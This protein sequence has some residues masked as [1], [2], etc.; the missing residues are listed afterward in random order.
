MVNL[1]EESNETLKLHCVAA[2]KISFACHQNAYPVIRELRIENLSETQIDDL[3]L[4]IES[5]PAF[6]KPKTW[7]IDRIE[8]G[9]NLPL[10]FKD[11][12]LKG[13]F[14][15]DLM[16]SVRGALHLRIRRKGVL[17]AEH[18]QPIELLTANEWGGAGYMPELLAAFCTPND[19]VV[20]Q[21]LRDAGNVLRR[22]GKSDVIDGYQSG[23]RQRVWEVA[24]A[25][26]A[27]ISN[28]GVS[29]AVPPSSF[30][31]DGQK[32][33][34]PSQIVKGG[35]A[36]CLDI[37]LLMAAV[38][39]Q[40]GLNSV[41]AL[42]KGH[43]LVGVWLQPEK[44][45][46]VLN[47]E[48]EV[49]RK[50]CQLNEL[51]ILEPTF[52]TSQP[53][54]A[55]SRAI[56]AAVARLVAERDG[57][58]IT[59]VDIG[60]AR[61]HRISPIGLRTAS[62]SIQSDLE[63]PTQVDLTLEAAPELPDF[64]QEVKDETPETAAGRLERWQR[65]LLDLSARN[66]LLNHRTTKSS[67]RFLCPDPEQLEDKLASGAKISI[68]ALPVAT[69][70]VQD[71][72]LHRQRSGEH[73]DEA[74]AAAALSENQ[75]LAELP[76]PELGK[77]VTEIYRKAKSS[78]QEGGANTL[79]LALGFLLWKRDSKD[80]RRFRAPLILLPVSLERQSIRSGVKMLA[81][82][83]E[84]RFN[85]TLLEMLQKDFGIAIKGYE[86]ALPSDGSGVDVAA[87]WTSVRRAVRDS[88][89]F[90]VVEDVV[91]GHFSFAKYLM[92][93]D[94]VD[95][96]DDL[97]KSPVV[98]HLIDS[99][100]DQY[101]SSIEFVGRDEIDRKYKPNDFLTPLP[102]DA[103][104]M[105][106]VATADRGKDFV[107]IGPPGTGKSQTISNLIAHMLGSGRTVLFVSEKT[108]ALEVVYRRL[109]QVG[110][111]RFCLQLHSNKA[112]K[113]DVLAQLQEAWSSGAERTE[114]EWETEAKQLE[115]LRDRLNQLVQ[116][117]H[118]QAR[119]GLTAHFAMGIK[120][121]DEKFAKRI[122]L[123]W[124]T[125]DQHTAEDL[126]QMREAVRSL[127]IQARAVGDISNSPFQAIARGDWSPS[128]EGEMHRLSL[129]LVEAAQGI[130]QE[131]SRLCSTLG[132]ELPDT[133]LARLEGLG[134]LA[135][136]LQQSYRKQAAGALGADG[137]ILIEALESA[138]SHL[139]AYAEAQTRLSCIY[140]PFAWRKLD[141]ADLESR[142]RTAQQHWFLK[143]FFAQRRITKEMKAG[144]AKDTPAPVLDAPV[145]AELRK[146]GEAIDNLDSQLGSLRDWAKHD[147]DPE[148]VDQ[149]RTLATRLRSAVAKL[150]DTPQALINARVK[151][152]ALL[153]EGNDLLAPDAPVGRA[154]ESY[155]G[156][157]TA[158]GGAI[159][160][161]DASAGK[162][163]REQFANEGHALELI[164]ESAEKIAENC[165]Q[166]NH[167]CSW[168]RE[169]NKA[170]ELG[171]G[172]LV[173][174]IESGVVPLEE[175]P[176]TFTAA[177]CNWWSTQLLNEDE[178]LRTF[179]SAAH[180]D[181][182]NRFR[183]LDET[184][185][186]VT[187][188]YVAARM[189]AG[190]PG[191]DEGPRSSQWGILKHQM[192]LRTRHKPV[193]QL[194]L[195]A[196]EAIARLAP[197]LM[198]SPLSVAQYL[199]ADKSLFDLVIFDE[200]SQ[201]S[202][203]D[204]VGSLARGKQII[205]AGD[206][207][208]MPPTNFFAR[209]DD[210]ADGDIDF[211]GDLESIL[212]ELRSSNV[213]ELV[214]N[215]HYRSRRES[216][217]AFSNS[218]YYDN[219]LVTFPAPEQPDNGLRLVAPEGFYDRGKS[220]CN[221]GEA[222]AIVE[223]IV[224]RLTSDDASVRQRSIG[225]VTFNT[226]QQSLIEDLLDRAR[227]DNPSLEAAFS[228]SLAEPVFVKNLETVQGDER[229]VILF[230]IT[231]GPDRA[232]H[233]TMNFG[234]LNRDGGERRLNVALTRARS[235]M[236]VF[237]TLKPE[238]IDL[239]RTSAR[240][241]ADLKHFLEYAKQGPAA[242]GSAVHGSIGDF[243]SP[244]ESAVARGLRKRGW[245]IHPQIGVSA[246]RIDLGVVHP[247]LPGVYLAGVECDG[248][249]YHSSAYARERDK[250]RQSV[251]ENL[252]WT[253]FRVWST[254]WWV[255]QSSA[256]NALDLQ[257]R[258]HLQGDRTERS[259]IKEAGV[260]ESESNT[261]SDNHILTASEPPLTQP[262]D[263]STG[264]L[265][266]KSPGSNAR[267][268]R[269]D[270]ES[271]TDEVGVA[272][273]Q[274]STSDA[275][276]N[277]SDRPKS[278]GTPYVQA[279]LKVDTGTEQLGELSVDVLIEPITKIVEIESPIHTDDVIRRIT[280]AAGL[281]RAGSRIQ[282]N[283]GKAI[284]AAERLKKIR[285]KGEFLWTS[286]RRA[287]SARDRTSLP[288]QDKKLERV[289]PEEIAIALINVVRRH[290]T[291]SQEDAIQESARAL[292][293]QRVT[294]PM[295]ERILTVMNRLKSQERIVEK[296]GLLS[297]NRQT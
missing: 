118:R 151:I 268:A 86:S 102:A 20:D 286:E 143:R 187:A 9:A 163:I 263:V 21:I 104:Q 148:K 149:L 293:F 193:R 264:K 70:Q 258:D 101:P 33:R 27:A 251:L 69:S 196:P 222:R 248:A 260:G 226:Q 45:A 219:G 190:L 197:C 211:E 42:V 82:D 139:K 4:T 224:S 16:E 220:R 77:R 206:P 203:W 109:E 30:E 56:E 131:Q 175:I 116:H 134:E 282:D 47:D 276:T 12:E 52:V 87:I 160:A 294:A 141:G 25:A 186:K 270:S 98:K 121:R 265:S 261:P 194:M 146:H 192:A 277:P 184:F 125:A 15:I 246:F 36:T 159:S 53:S 280:H 68:R 100:R 237:S 205:V 65:K 191:Q 136:A 239:K 183:A 162:S 59:A 107:L 145:L 40:A 212:D 269:E 64:D 2:A 99:P 43:A 200:A 297:E 231:F 177:Y 1:A 240:A 91:L 22:A 267:S 279:V 124:A 256:L 123:E 137:Q 81:H 288:P 54:P 117:L 243:E 119:N 44:L 88:S 198:M 208:Q 78:L 178:V 221:E 140:D 180:V 71:R 80:E 95:R 67:I 174:G 14:L 249:M 106:A 209:A 90:E 218:H 173:A 215:L 93:K 35:V 29:Y 225:V 79:Y 272:G 147:S 155:L 41:I 278:L 89:G 48:A 156:A 49:L 46:S 113:A 66:P 73:I 223:E 17:V 234:P 204:A 150:V 92:W 55:F 142:W 216:L 253:L 157:L 51:V 18:S 213:S 108:A 37:A 60:R 62:A 61:A 3:T 63:K 161:F 120:I 250:I 241:V 179:S 188:R 111:G 127:Q 97:R 28:L 283:L 50:R 103:S 85:T 289:A 166:L 296:S 13:Q 266:S 273:N 96:T 168:Q 259:K 105:A 130:E 254:D 210:D 32:I 144:G 133:A 39:E 169:R 291:L 230:S 295:N 58:F 229:D 274:Q 34:F 170:I 154:T 26:Y 214:L 5:D 19:P 38:F 292:G 245:T 235:E 171:L 7:Q 152:R 6:L 153:G 74:Y 24:G 255:D 172:N 126:E 189:S 257:I 236:V 227:S 238:M 165:K 228:E 207:K 31:L 285:K 201:I 84:P 132:L 75:V 232:G 112:K 158:L 167:W 72:D 114:A 138:L 57:E 135:K 199:P 122:N 284:L 185:M 242:L 252:G 181:T 281:Q 110:L 10:Q 217:I 94:L 128:W 76:A 195:E 164:R 244:F 271:G 287:F 290:F 129:A 247:D 8:A 176:E 115:G 233:L 262:D 11:F 83:D 202:V 275:N 23:S 182:I